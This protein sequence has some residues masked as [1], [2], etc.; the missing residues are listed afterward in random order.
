MQLLHRGPRS[1]HDDW[2]ELG[3]PGELWQMHKFPMISLRAEKP[4]L[5]CQKTRG[6]ASHPKLCHTACRT[7][8]AP[9]LCALASLHG[10]N[11][12]GPAQMSR[13]PLPVG[14][15]EH[16]LVS[17]EPCRRARHPGRGFLG[18]SLT[19]ISKPRFE[20]NVSVSVVVG[21]YDQVCST[22]R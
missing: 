8:A 17:T 1:R 10:N 5:A 18:A 7:P 2:P 19:L 22:R 13:N 3:T 15:S 9:A 12:I 4:H 6:W 11:S 21:P 14:P 20:T 16:D